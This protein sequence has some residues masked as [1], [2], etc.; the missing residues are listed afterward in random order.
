MK[1]LGVAAATLAL[2]LVP[3]Q[4][5]AFEMNESMNNGDD[6]FGTAPSSS[7]EDENTSFGDNSSNVFNQDEESGESS[8]GDSNRQSRD[9]FFNGGDNQEVDIWE[10]S[11]DGASAESFDG[12]EQGTF[13]VPE[14]VAELE[15]EMD[16]GAPAGEPA[17]E[18]HDEPAGAEPGGASAT[19]QQETAPEDDLLN[20][21]VEDG[22]MFGSLEEEL[23]E[24][25]DP[26]VIDALLQQFMGGM[27]EGMD[28]GM[29]SGSGG[30]DMNQS[31]DPML[32]AP[33]G[34]GEMNQ[35]DPAMTSPDV[36]MP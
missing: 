33:A 3:N 8:F 26:E 31:L 7:F 21:T 12:N 23:M 28:P 13:G 32:N 6:S 9:A 22:D 25:G 36:S 30:F 2:F 14:R 20:E 17:P 34:T 29:G 10:G 18:G 4:T 5:D 11:G 15:E 1:K 16:S 19:E 35:M 27:N 24:G